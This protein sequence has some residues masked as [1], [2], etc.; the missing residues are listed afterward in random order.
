MRIS[1]P[2]A[3]VSFNFCVPGLVILAGSP[4]TLLVPTNGLLFESFVL[5]DIVIALPCD[6]VRVSLLLALN[7]AVRL[8]IPAAVISAAISSAIPTA[9]P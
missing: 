2:S 3:R 4:D 8:V 5:L 7:V 1:P 9:I 6:S